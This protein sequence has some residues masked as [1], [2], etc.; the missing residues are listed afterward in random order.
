M[1]KSKDNPNGRRLSRL[2]SFA[3]GRRYLTYASLL[4]SA[5]SA[6]LSVVPYYYIWLILDEVL[7]AYPDLGDATGIVHNGWMAVGFTVLSVA[8]YIAA[9]MCSHLAAFRQYCGADLLHASRRQPQARAGKIRALPCSCEGLVILERFPFFKGETLK[10][11]DRMTV[12]GRRFCVA[13]AAEGLFPATTGVWR[14]C[15]YA[16]R[17]CG[18]PY[19]AA[20]LLPSFASGKRTNPAAADGK[21]C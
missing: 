10:N 2:A 5:V 12:C 8:L 1:E 20:P 7:A 13:V 9:L 6:A 19:R 14:Q 16:V 18:G 3:G 15:L 21:C 4:L 17:G 11:G